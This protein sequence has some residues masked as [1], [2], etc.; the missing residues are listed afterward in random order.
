MFLNFE[1]KD[2]KYCFIF[3][4]EGLLYSGPVKE[5]NS[6]ENR[7]T[8]LQQDISCYGQKRV[9][10]FD[11]KE[12]TSR[13]YL[14]YSDDRKV[15]EEIGLHHLFLD[16]VKIKNFNLC[17]QYISQELVKIEEELFFEFFGPNGS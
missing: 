5:I 14:V 7:L 4:S 15:C 9:F 6:T 12:N 16:A 13:S 2:V 8:I 10:D 17:K 11:L 3:D 1:F